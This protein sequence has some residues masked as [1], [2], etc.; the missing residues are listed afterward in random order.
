[1]TPT[2]ITLSYNGIAFND[3]TTDAERFYTAVDIPE[4]LSPVPITSGSER[5]PAGHGAVFGRNYYGLR[6][7][8]LQG[9]I[10]AT[11]QEERVTMEQA[12]IAAFTLPRDT[13]GFRTLTM[14]GEDGLPRSVSARPISAV[15]LAKEDGEPWKRNYTVTLELATEF[16]AGEQET[17]TAFDG[18]VN[19]SF[20]IA[21]D[22]Q[23][24]TDTFQIISAPNNF[25]LVNNAGNYAA[26]PYIIFTGGGENPKIT[27]ETTGRFMHIETTFDAGEEIH[28][29]VQNNRIFLRDG[30]T[31]TDLL[32]SLS[33]TSRLLFLEPG[34]N[35]LTITDEAEGVS[36]MAAAVTFSPSYI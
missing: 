32:A 23:I 2:E 17:D 26:A 8:T 1:M 27:N 15:L 12:L 21:P 35:Y 6:T 30:E 28:V 13:D 31:D 22:F 16:F 25:I 18:I 34:N 36:V 5:R 29:D 19:T 20:Q 4:S 24:I 33:V 3:F 11:T 9:E 7:F 10:I 14:I